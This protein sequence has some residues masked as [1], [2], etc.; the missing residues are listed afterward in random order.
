MTIRA[1]NSWLYILTTG[2]LRAWQA[3]GDYSVDPVVAHLSP[4]VYADP[5]LLWNA[6]ATGDPT[7]YALDQQYGLF[8]DQDYYQD[9]G[10]VGSRWMRCSSPD[11]KLP[12]VPFTTPA[13]PA[14]S[15][16]Q[17]ARWPGIV[18]AHGAAGAWDSLSCYNPRVVKHLDGTPYRNAAGTYFMSYIG[19]SVDTPEHDQSGLACADSLTVPAWSK[20]AAN[21]WIGCGSTYDI[22]D[23]QVECVLFDGATFHVW[24]DANCMISGG[25]QDSIAYANGPDLFSLTKRGVVVQ[26]VTGQD[27]YG[28]QVFP[29]GNSFGMVAVRHIGSVYGLVRLDA[30][31]LAGPWTE[32]AGFAFTHP[33]GEAYSTNV[34][35]EGAN[36]RLLY[37]AGD[38]GN[39]RCA[40]AVGSGAFI[41]QGIILPPGVIGPLSYNPYGADSV[42][43]GSV[44]HMFFN[45]DPYNGGIGRAFATTV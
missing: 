31:S 24:Y 22:G 19:S 9:A 28:A 42:R 11:A 1:Y 21:P 30:P 32:R 16:G 38:Y 18:L 40:Y 37:D 25:D 27:Y 15:V 23:V 26:S 7:L 14:V 17:W 12:I 6:S 10:I 43:E 33:S 3:T 35:V 13:I 44:E 2:E 36:L 5:S 41:D 29:H 39:I 8:F 4:S 45:A 34:R 20:I